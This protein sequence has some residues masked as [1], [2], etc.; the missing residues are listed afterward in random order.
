MAGLAI[1]PLIFAISATPY[2]DIKAAGEG[3][4]FIVL[5]Q[6]FRKMGPAGHIYAAFFFVAFWF[7]AFTSLITIHEVALR[8]LKD[9]GLKTWQAATV[10]GI[11]AFLCG[12][13][14]ALSSTW[15]D[16]YDTVWGV[17]GLAVGLVFISLITSYLTGVS[18]IREKLMDMDIKPFIRL[19]K[20]WD[21]L[22]KANITI[23]LIFFAWWIVYGEW[24]RGWGAGLHTYYT[25]PGM[26]I[27]LIGGVTM[28]FVVSRAIE[29]QFR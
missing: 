17:A 13:P 9:F 29:K 22:I 23:P 11:L 24:I 6:L 20:W 16:Y 7:A 26:L 14:T 4:A 12:V 3:L 18:R 27:L 8:P 19:G 10:T 21:V 25:Y 28:Y 15:L 5:P 1:I 2:E